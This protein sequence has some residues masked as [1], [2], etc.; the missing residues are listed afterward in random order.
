MRL[1]FKNRNESTYAKVISLLSLVS[2]SLLLLVVALYFYMR[3]QEK[4]IFK[5]S[6][7]IYKNEIN[8]LLKLNSESYTSISID[9]TYWDEFVD[10]VKTRDLDWFNTSVASVLDA[11]KL[12][13]ISVYSTEGE[14]ITKVSTTKIKSK[15][16]IPKEAIDILLTKKVDHFFLK[17]PDGIVEV[18]GATIHPSDDPFKNKYEPSGCFFMVRLLDNEYFAD[19]EKISTSNIKFY[20]G[21]EVAEKTVFSVVPLQDYKQEEVTSLY[22]KRAYKIDFWIT[23]TILLIMALAI[24]ISWLV[25]YVYANKWSKLPLSFIKKILREGDQSA[26]HSLKNIKGE[27]RYIGKLF[28]ENQRQ[29]K[30]LEKAK[31]KAEESDKLKSA[32]LMNLS[33]EVRT[34]MNA[35]IG[36]S[37][38]LSN[39]N[40]SED[41]RNEYVKVIQESGKNLIAIIDDL[42]EMSKIDS[43]LIKPNLQ[44]FNLKELIEGI[45]R[46]YKKLYESENV[47]FK[48]ISPKSEGQNFF[49]RSDKTKLSEII[50]NLLNNSYKFTKNGFVIL[51]YSIDADKNNINISVKDSG[52]GIPEKFQ[53][54]IFKR[55]SKINTSGISG[56]EGLGLG[57]AISHAYVDMLGGSINFESQENVGTTF[58][59]SIPL[60]KSDSDVSHNTMQFNPLIPIDLGDEEII[61]VVEDDNINYLLIEKVLKPFGCNVLRAKDGLEA[62]R[63]CKE[64]NEIDLVLMDIR[65]PNMDGYEAFLKIREFNKTIPIVAQTSYSFEEELNKIKQLGFNG[66]ISKPINKEELFSLIQRYL[67]K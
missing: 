61:L 58:F 3:M 46:T 37:D 39:K 8:T 13:Y 4:E 51:E 26:I 18:F 47:E 55:F 41:E 44:D 49:I 54:N 50:I 60:I 7:D 28:E 40:L 53:E 25:Y 17:I 35:V 11:Y 19:I 31:T 57:L 9:V 59:I 27:F 20:D 42:V 29:T 34:P 22:F 63:L 62:V 1:F 16:F 10:F 33:H 6:N 2:I 56:N 48:L 36:F 65:M 38:L 64:N 5:S 67:K 23:K 12:E 15:G 24:I 30:E 14:L 45:F 52:E 43:K 66:F 21:N 32:F